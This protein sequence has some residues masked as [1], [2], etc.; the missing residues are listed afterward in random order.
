MPLCAVVLVCRRRLELRRA[1][2][3]VKGSL[4]SG[5]EKA[6]TNMA[7]ANINEIAAAR[8]VLNNA[9]TAE[10]KAF[11]QKMVDDHSSA[12]TRVKAVAQQK[13][14]KLPDEPDAKYKAM[15]GKLEK[16][17]GDAFDKMYMEHAGVKDH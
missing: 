13:G 6:L 11:A 8:I 10:V 1:Q 14:V 15:A 3:E 4:S 17:S 2:T 12:L 16:L 5:D 7:Q 9:Q